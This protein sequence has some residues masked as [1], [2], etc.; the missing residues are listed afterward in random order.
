MI[1]V[2]LTIEVTDRCLNSC[3]HC[4]S[5]SSKDKQ[6]ILELDRALSIIDELNPGKVVISGGEPL[7]Y[8]HL[9]YLIQ[10]LHDR[11]IPIG[12]NTAG[13]FDPSSI[14]NNILMVDEFYLSYF[15]FDN[16]TIVCSTKDPLF[17]GI[18]TRMYGNA[19]IWINTIIFNERQIPELAYTAFQLKIPILSLI[20]I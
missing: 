4:S 13:N 17:F 8:P 11:G 7:L 10:Y 3:I 16:E 15:C 20:H 2:E 18:L 12:L 6:T 9:K 19:K 14:P 1:L 5:D